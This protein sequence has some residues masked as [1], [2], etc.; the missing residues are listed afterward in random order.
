MKYILNQVVQMKI[1]DDRIDGGR[2]FDWGRTSADYAMYRDIYPPAFYDRILRRGLCTAGQTVL[3]LGT[4][5]GVLP[6]HLASY[7]A[8]WTGVDI[9]PEQI[10]QAKRLSQGLD[11]V[12]Y[13]LPAEKLP[14]EDHTFDVVTACQCFWYFDHDMLMPALVRMMKPGG[15]LLVL[16]M[17]WLPYEDA[18]AGASERLVLQYN[19]AWSGAG[20]TEHPIEIPDCYQACFE[21]AAHEEFR[22]RVPF[23]RQSW[24]GRMKACRGV[25]ASLSDA[26]VAAWEREHLQMLTRTAPETFEV[27]HYAALA[28]LRLKV[29]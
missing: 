19:P 15:V 4:G 22:L 16:Y 6:R 28:E 26:E 29:R 3:D 27:L 8:H 5:T 1:T 10:A 14:F 23:T 18:I 9:S 2:A 21:P 24:H 20:E 12:Y 25:G 11:I 17:A 7:G 13:A